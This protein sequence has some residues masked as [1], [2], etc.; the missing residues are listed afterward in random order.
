[1]AYV[2]KMLEML[3]RKE[4]D[5]NGT[6]TGTLYVG[7]FKSADGTVDCALIFSAEAPSTTDS[8]NIG[9]LWICITAGSVKISIKT[10]STTWT[11][12]SSNT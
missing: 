2:V 10:A 7:G 12:V 5:S 6:G 1:M 8:Y 3:V 9:S 4:T 11:A